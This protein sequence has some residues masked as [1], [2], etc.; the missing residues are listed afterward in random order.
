MKAIAALLVALLANTG[1]F[2]ADT[3]PDGRDALAAVEALGRLNGQALACNQPAISSRARTAVIT[4]AP[5]TRGYGEAFEA[6]TNAA[7]LEQ[8]RGSVCPDAA[9]LSQELAAGES[10]LRAALAAGQ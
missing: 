10:R 4:G 8:G 2:A 6:A 3:A 1:A 5:K 7:F 9:T